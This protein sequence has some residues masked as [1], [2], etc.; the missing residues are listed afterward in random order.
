[1]Q[2][3]RDDLRGVAT[4][5]QRPSRDPARCGQAGAGTRS[6]NFSAWF[7]RVL[8]WGMD[9][10]EG[11]VRLTVLEEHASPVVPRQ[12][13]IVLDAKAKAFVFGHKRVLDVS[14]FADLLE[15]NRRGVRDRVVL[16]AVPDSIAG[17]LI[18]FLRTRHGGGPV[19]GERDGCLSFTVC[20]DGI[21]AGGRPGDQNGEW[22][23]DR[24]RCPQAPSRPRHA[25]QVQ[26]RQMQLRLARNR[27]PIR[28]PAS[29]RNS[30]SI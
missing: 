27:D 16:D 14:R 23:V 9:D 11:L 6:I 20:S 28:Q 2:R 29:R 19:C 3:R 7:D 1:M 5:S 26:F 12:F 22:Q 30:R 24:I 15:A 25:H 18:E 10:G 8:P 17:R 21:P 13:R 4:V